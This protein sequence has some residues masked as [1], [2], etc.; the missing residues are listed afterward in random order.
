MKMT[1]S[2]IAAKNDPVKAQR[3]IAHIVT[4]L[5]ANEEWN[6]DEMDSIA[7]AVQTATAGAI[8]DLPSW[9]DQDVYAMNFWAGVTW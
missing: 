8:D 4:V 6:V 9:T 7:T 5:G 2:E 3:A 1:I